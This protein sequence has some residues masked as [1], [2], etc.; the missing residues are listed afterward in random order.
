ME[1][2]DFQW[3][4]IFRFYLFRDFLIVE[5]FIHLLKQFTNDFFNLC[6]KCDFTF[7]RL[8]RLQ[9][10]KR[11]N[12]DVGIGDLR[13]DFS[14]DVLTKDVRLLNCREIFD[15]P[16]VI[17]GLCFV[18]LFF[19]R[20]FLWNDILRGVRVSESVFFLCDYELI[21]VFHGVNVEKPSVPFVSNSASVCDFRYQVPDGLPWGLLD[22]LRLLAHD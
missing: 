4:L 22:D 13:R 11:L 1:Q 3:I 20:L 15:F 5:G 14:V 18:V 19:R 21:E 6:F 10:F 7:V 12:E 16:H 8:R 9:C 17:L 2:D